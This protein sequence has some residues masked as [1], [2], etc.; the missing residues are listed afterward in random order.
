MNYRCSLDESWTRAGDGWWVTDPTLM[1]G[2]PP[3]DENDFVSRLRNRPTASAVWSTGDSLLLFSGQFCRGSLFY[4]RRNGVLWIS[5]DLRA[6]V[7]NGAELNP[8]AVANYVFAKAFYFDETPFRGILKVS[9]GCLC[10]VSERGTEETYLDLIRPADEPCSATGFLERLKKAVEPLHDKRVM[11]TLSG[12]LDSSFVAAFVRRHVSCDLEG[13]HVHSSEGDP[14]YS[15]VD[16]ARSFA[17]AMGIP[18]RIVDF[19]ADRFLATFPHFCSQLPLPL[20]NSGYRYYLLHRYGGRE[21]PLDYF[22]SGDAS[23]TLFELS[24]DFYVF[25]KI[26]ALDRWLPVSVYRRLD[27]L[28]D[29]W[30]PRRRLLESVRWRV[31]RYCDFRLRLFHW[32]GTK[33]DYNGEWREPFCGENAGGDL[34]DKIYSRGMYDIDNRLYLLNT[35]FSYLELP[36]FVPITKKMFR[37]R[38]LTPFLDPHV[39][40]LALNLS[41]AEAKEK[42]FLKDV[43]S[44][45]V[46]PSTIRRKKMG[47]ILPFERWLRGP[48]REAVYDLVCG[49]GGLIER[50]LLE[51]PVL[52]NLVDGF[53]EGRG[54]LGWCEVMALLSLEV[55][56][57]TA[58]DPPVPPADLE[59]ISLPELA[60]LGRNAWA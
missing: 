25:N 7:E 9:H 60:A 44:N 2:G 40:S 49:K 57:R 38:Y 12:G 30:V 19:T 46:P 51:P 8:S 37:A 27:R 32:K 31:N 48:A 43:A 6:L 33:V 41:V 39:I 52:K 29:R 58:V 3:R 53:F 55:W 35:Y 24:P 13:F 23:D 28:L 47:L 14:A 18:L 1:A 21:G 22:V 11:A 56:L 5:S 16:Q 17:D 54:P 10:R 4:V 34:V 15:E 59:S 45:Y 42:S 36:A 26:N 20:P 50:G